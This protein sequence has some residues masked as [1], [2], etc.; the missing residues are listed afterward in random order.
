[1]NNIDIKVTCLKDGPLMLE[2]NV[3][4]LN[5]SGEIIREAEKMFLCRCGQ[6]NNKPFCDG[7]HKQINFS[8]G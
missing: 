8:A 7:K 1:M 6:S 4:V 3:K 5:A 2:G